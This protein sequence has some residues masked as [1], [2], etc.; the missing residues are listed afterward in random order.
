MPTAQRHLI[1]SSSSSRIGWISRSR[2]IEYEQRRPALARPGEHSGPSRLTLV[3]VPHITELGYWEITLL[4]GKKVEV[5][6]D[7]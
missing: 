5:C 7:G 6:A 2:L 1:T 4:D 3:A